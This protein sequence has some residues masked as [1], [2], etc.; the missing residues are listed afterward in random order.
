MLIVVDDWTG[1]EAGILAVLLALGS[2]TFEGSTC[3]ILLK[4]TANTRRPSMVIAGKTGRE[5][6]SGKRKD[7]LHSDQE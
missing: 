2:V 4:R 6:G 3:C 1:V 7:G 5:G